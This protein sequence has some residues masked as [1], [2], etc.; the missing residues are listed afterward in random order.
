MTIEVGARKENESTRSASGRQT[1]GQQ[2]IAYGLVTCFCKLSF[3]GT[4][5]HP[6]VY[7][8]SVTAFAL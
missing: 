5:S 1:K 7:V 4:Q 3:I 6:F 2:T 8:L